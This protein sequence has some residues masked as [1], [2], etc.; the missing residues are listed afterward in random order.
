MALV[1]MPGGEMQDL[2]RRYANTVRRAAPARRRARRGAARARRARL[3]IDW[4]RSPGSETR[5]GGR[6]AGTARRGC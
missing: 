4:P 6:A 2:A 1:M 3:C 5:S